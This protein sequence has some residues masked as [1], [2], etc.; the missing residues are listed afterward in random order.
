MAPRDRVIDALLALAA[1]E[2]FEDITLRQIAER[3]GVSLADFRELYASKFAVLAAFGRRIDRVVLEGTTGDLAGEDVK[4]R[5]FDVLMRRFDALAPYREGVKGVAE[6][7]R[8][9]PMAAAAVNRLAVA[10]MRF[11]LEAADIETGGRVGALKA[12]GLALALARVTRI[13][14]D[15]EDAGLATT[16]A[17]LDRA[18]TR[19]GKLVERAKDVERI[20]SPLRA[21]ARGVVDAG[22]TFARSRRDGFRSRRDRSA[23]AAANE[24]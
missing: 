5:L 20:V 6:W 3:A 11:M 16:M 8:R 14:L 24:I 2:R 17:E 13:W 12:Q 1:E 9:E 18:L 19:G 4:E 15:D 7:M 22:F 21:M 23:D 10:S